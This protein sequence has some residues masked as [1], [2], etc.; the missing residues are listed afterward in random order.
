VT[1]TVSPG[2]WALTAL[3]SSSGLEIFVPPSEVTTSPVF[4]PALAAGVPDR[5]PAISAF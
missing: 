5:T 4:S 2:L 3:A 1:V